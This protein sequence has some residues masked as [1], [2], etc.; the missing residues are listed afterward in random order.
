MSLPSY[1]SSA[2]ARPEARLSVNSP[3]YRDRLVLEYRMPA[4]GQ[5]V[6]SEGN[7]V[8]IGLTQTPKTLPPKYFYDDLGSQLFEAITGLPEYYLTRTERSILAASAEAIAQ[9]VGSCDLIELGSGSS[10]K[11]RLL[12]DAFQQADQSIRYIP[13]DV[14]GGIL[15]DSAHALLAEYPTLAVHGLVGTYDVALAHLPATKLPHRLIAFIGS[16]LGNLSPRE[17]HQF[18]EQ[19]SRALAPGDFFL[20]GVDLHKDTPTLEAAYD[21][22]QGVTAAFNLNML[23]HLNWRFVGNFDLTQ[24]RHVSLYNDRDRQIEMYLESLSNQTVTLQALDLTVLFMAGERLLSE[25]S[26][27]FEVYSLFQELLGHGLQVIH[28]FQDPRSWFALLLCR[29]QL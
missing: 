18:F 19:V 9:T 3:D 2:S 26:R 14:S 22:A 8:V 6:E 1:P 25:I 23:N 5:A 16:T 17:C 7:D 10:S 13:V 4:P 21:D 15:K 12:L 29:K 27:K 20:L 24:F 28:T 11:T